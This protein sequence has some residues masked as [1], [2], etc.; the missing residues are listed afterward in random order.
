LLS[1][2]ASPLTIWSVVNE[3][4]NPVLDLAHVIENLN[5]LDIGS[6]E[7]ILLGVP[8]SI[9]SIAKWR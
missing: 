7:K 9:A 5:K 6:P 3:E 8:F 2:T 4:G 1:V